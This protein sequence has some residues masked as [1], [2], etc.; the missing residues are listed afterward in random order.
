MM[1]NRKTVMKKHF[2][3]IIIV[4][5]T[6]ILMIIQMI[7]AND[8]N[9]LARSIQVGVT[10]IVVIL[11]TKWLKRKRADKFVADERVKAVGAKAN[12]MTL[13]IFLLGGFLA[14]QIS[15]IFSYL[16]P[17]LKIV[18][19]TLLVAI[20]ATAIVNRLLYV[21]YNRKMS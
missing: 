20:V 3:E 4:A 12:S 21:F 11:T 17:E 6:I 8:T 15:V 10:M 16:R 18:T 19:N 7:V 1:K 5:T 2:W 13:F 14:C 9:L